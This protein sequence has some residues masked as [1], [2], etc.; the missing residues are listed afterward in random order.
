VTYL[1]TGEQA[2]LRETVRELAEKKIAP[3]AAEVDAAG[4]FPQEALEALTGA[5]ARGAHP[6]R[7]RWRGR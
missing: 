3:A 2:L 1:L 7:L 5:R 4:R 6:R